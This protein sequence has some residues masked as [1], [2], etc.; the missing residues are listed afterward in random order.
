MEMAYCIVLMVLQS[1]K[2]GRRNRLQTTQPM[3]PQ[4]FE[5][6][7]RF[8]PCF[9]VSHCRSLVMILEGLP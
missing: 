9:N 4:N 7:G 5:C 2:I 3:Y 6:T 1:N 8:Y